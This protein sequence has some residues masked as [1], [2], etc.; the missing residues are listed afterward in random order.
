[1]RKDSV[2]LPVGP[3]ALRVWA[4]VVAAAL[5]VEAAFI[6][7]WPLSIRF[8]VDQLLTG[9]DY[10]TL[11]LLLIILV[12]GTALALSVG[13]L[14]D[15]F[16]ARVRSQWLRDLR[17]RMFEK[18]QGLTLAFQSRSEP[19][20]AHS[21]AAELL[22]R[23]S[24]D[25]AV[26]ENAV[27]LAVSWGILPV[28]E[29]L[30]AAAFM[31]WLE[32]RLALAACLLWP[33]ILAA[34]GAAGRRIMPATEER[35]KHERGLL[36]AVRESLSAQP[37]IRAFSLEP[38]GIS[39]FR[40]R[41]DLLSRSTFR[42]GL[43]S[44]FA[45]RL[46]RA[47]ILTVQ[48]FILALGMWMAFTRQITPGTLV[49]LQMLAL[50]LSGALLRVA[51][52]LPSVAEARAA[53]RRIGE[54]IGAPRRVVDRPDARF[55]PPIQAEILFSNVDF[56]YDGERLAL[57]GIKAR[58]PRGSYTAFV[59]PS[60][61]GKSTLLHLLMRLYDPSAGFITIDGHDL[62]SVTQASLRRR[63]GAVLQ[64][65]SI[66]QISVRENIRIGRPDASEA[67]IVEIAKAV[68]LHETIMAMPEGYDTVPGEHGA[69]FSVAGMQRLAIARAILRDPE[70][71]LLDEVTSALDPADEI[72]VTR[73]LRR[74]AGKRT[75][76]AAAHRLS[77][78][79][80]ADRIVV[81]DEG[82]IVEQGSHYELLAADGV[83]ANLWR[84]QAGFTF[85]MD[86]RHVDVDAR[87]LRAF[88][89]LGRLDEAKLAELAP[90][91]ATETFEPGREIVRQN[92]PGDKFYIIAR[93]KV[94]VWRTEE[95]SG[96]TASLAIL[97]DG[98][99]FGE[100]TLI[101][102]FPRTATV[103]A[104]TLCT[105]ISLARGQFNRMMDRFPELREHLS[106]I[107]LQRLR[108]SSKAIAASAL[109]VL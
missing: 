40:R 41:N 60:G 46:R 26:I 21:R 9:H 49:A 10:H 36:G 100:I 45:E 104:K 92:D 33:W 91:F 28:M 65:N 13:T 81:L 73:T 71:L 94:E 15:S 86:G 88:P 31:L 99:F 12:A 93:G 74:L 59:G 75:V 66:F 8:F 48:T 55:L 50:V 78:V 106:K 79:A 20:N 54:S 87:R 101:T 103:R 32:W 22:D 58:I 14:R 109:A 6:G 29:A 5:L 96:N 76:L 108:E 67:A 42:E 3:K 85:S 72:E 90:F 64:E 98:D 18:A 38:M 39:G 62:K 43:L 82:A 105:C 47:G 63:I 89:I 95:R 52:Y 23:F 56:S 11:Y 102:G 27:A 34:P 68:G 77:T 51:E 2:A 69:D 107:A 57:N 37:V 24:D 7:L 84:K 30:F 16:V 4:A 1:M 44:A 53:W 19:P 97:Q 35:E 17:Q 25:V 61:A 80:D 70:I 83:Y